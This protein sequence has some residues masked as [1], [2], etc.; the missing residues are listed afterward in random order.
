[1]NHV[2]KKSLTM[3]AKVILEN[4]LT[5]NSIITTLNYDYEL[6]TYCDEVVVLDSDENVLL[7]VKKDNE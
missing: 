3:L 6:V 5:I 4:N 2:D 7:S 1:M